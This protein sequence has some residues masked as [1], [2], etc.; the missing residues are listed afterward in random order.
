MAQAQ[1]NPSAQRSQV[2]AR[3]KFNCVFRLD[4]P[5]NG[6]IVVC[7]SSTYIDQNK[8]AISLEVLNSLLISLLED[9]HDM[10]VIRTNGQDCINDVYTPIA[11]NMA[12]AQQ[13][14]H[15]MTMLLTLRGEQ[16]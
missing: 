8:L 15:I 11:R 16:E 3:H 1:P 12:D 7:M 10:A 5:T 14:A 2:N 4:F 6:S 9:T 13:V